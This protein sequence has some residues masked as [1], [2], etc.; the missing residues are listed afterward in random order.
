M[1]FL[2][3]LN[4][5]PPWTQYRSSLNSMSFLP[6]LSAVPPWTQC[7][8][9]LNSMAF[10][11]ELNAVPPRFQCRSSLNSFSFFPELV[12]FP[13][14]QCRSSQNSTQ[15]FTGT[16][17][18]F[19]PTFSTLHHLHV[20]GRPSLQPWI[21]YFPPVSS[22]FLELLSNKNLTPSIHLKPVTFFLKMFNSF[23]LSWKV[24]I[25]L[26]FS[27]LS[28][29]NA[30]FKTF[31]PSLSPILLSAFISSLG[32]FVSD[33]HRQW[34]RPRCI[35]CSFLGCVIKQDFLSNE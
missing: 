26:I 18:F 5:V 4:T 30:S 23:S 22:L 33:S 27:S 12:I 20:Q 9:S 7:R 31:C 19:S 24:S 2:P 14:T 35:H 15:F 1:L 11:P 8:S 34:L 32:R 3:E 10:L 25:N 16:C 17:Y 28:K 21:S 29:C 13:W 6:E